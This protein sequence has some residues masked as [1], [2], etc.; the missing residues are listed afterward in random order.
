[1]ETIPDIIMRCP[2]CCREFS[3]EETYCEECTAMLEPVEERAGTSRM[4]ATPLDEGP[5][6]ATAQEEKLEDAGIDALKTDIEERFIHTL[7]SELTLLKNRLA[8]KEK[9]L[10][11]LTA[12]HQDATGHDLVRRTG[13]A[14]SQLSDILKKTA[15]IES[16]LD[17][18]REKIEA[19][20][21]LLQKECEGTGVQGIFGFFA[22]QSRY[23]KLRSS[24]L[25][26]KKELLRVIKEKAHMRRPVRLIVLAAS[27]GLFVIMAAALIVSVTVAARKGTPAPPPQSPAV[28]QT[29]AMPA[30]PAAEEIV[31]LLR[32]I[33]AANMRKDISLWQSCYSRSYLEQQSRQDE[34]SALWKTYDYRSLSYRIEDIL[35]QPGKATAVIIWDMELKSLETGRS[36]SLS[37]RLSSDFVV[38]N[39]KVRI[40]S[41]RMMEQ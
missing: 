10:S 3:L 33:R 36:I 9:E 12:D 2:K 22:I 20:I 31:R 28:S 25:K 30:A 15:T 35:T 34:I 40:V 7:L 37:Q 6:D 5:E 23:F 13:K 18:L 19:D 39:G 11:V 8:K 27:L 4:T 24:E 21:A 14:E 17:R 16:V 29:A 26:R 1:M 38:E 32:D 41:V